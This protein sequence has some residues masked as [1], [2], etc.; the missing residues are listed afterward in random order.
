MM[1]VSALAVLTACGD[2]V[3]DLDGLMDSAEA[4]AVMRS[5]DQLPLLPGFIDATENVDGAGTRLLR[6]RELW[7][8]GTASTEA[9]GAA[10]RRLA[11][12]YAAPVL[13]E[14]V[15]AEEWG[16]ARER[17]DDWM[18]TASAMLRHL[19]I[20]RVETQLEAA[21][22]QLRRS[23]RAATERD[24]VYYLLLAGSELV[25]TTPRFVAR[26][27]T[28][29][30]E[31]VVTRARSARNP[32]VPAATLERAKRLKDWAARAM[33]DGDHLL[34]IQRAYYAMQLLEER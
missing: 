17:I 2:D 12:G 19:S 27:M 32:S 23:D 14:S 21:A 8:A 34:A 16:T 24:R 10:R 4:E 9:S 33:E 6:A 7:D 28:R 1:V 22:R 30:A 18:V 11:V 25:E 26:S 20:P 31:R 3:T 13:V 15:P 5:A 29:D